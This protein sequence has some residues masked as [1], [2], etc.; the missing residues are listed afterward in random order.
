MGLE[1][2]ILLKLDLMYFYFS[3]RFSFNKILVFIYFQLVILMFKLLSVIDAKATI[4]IYY[5][6]FILFQ[7]L[8]NKMF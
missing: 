3:F 2:R 8:V 6:Y 1:S 7:L 4:Q 5:I